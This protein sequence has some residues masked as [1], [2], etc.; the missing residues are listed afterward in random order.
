MQKPVL[1]ALFFGALI[2][3]ALGFF[4]VF[5][6]NFLMGTPPDGEKTDAT[7]YWNV[8]I[9]VPF[10]QQSEILY[11]LERNANLISQLESPEQV[12]LCHSQ[13]VFEGENP[14]VSALK[15]GLEA[16]HKRYILMMDSNT[17][18][19][20]EYLKSVFHA[21]NKG[22]TGLVFS[23][24]SAFLPQ[25]DCEHVDAAI[26]N[27]TIFKSMIAANFMGAS[28][29]MGKAMMLDSKRID[30]KEAFEYI[31]P[32][33]AEDTR[34]AQFV[35]K[36][37]CKIR[38]STL[39]IVQTYSSENPTFPFCRMVRWFRLLMMNS[40]LYFVMV[41]L[42]NPL[43]QIVIYYLFA[44]A[45]GFASLEVCLST[46]AFMGILFMG[47][48]ALFSIASPRGFLSFSV[49]VSKSVYCWAAWLVAPFSRTVNWRGR[50]LK[51]TVRGKISS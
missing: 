49:W 29:A 34:L 37:G 11:F 15:R 18:A 9:L 5:V 43:T 35:S 10:V 19:G 46:L 44:K 39:P 51:L 40:P 28:I 7:K 32:Y 22:N 36:K 38:I 3:D 33:I 20:P 48:V 26:I 25:S 17:Y 21:M 6:W 24:V 45:V 47:D 41:P 16:C 27:T 14:K 42:E 50:K 2:L 13:A 30:A 23:P 31:T 1:E 8:N 4:S 12:V